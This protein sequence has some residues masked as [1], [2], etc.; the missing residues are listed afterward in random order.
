MKKRNFGAPTDTSPSIAIARPDDTR[1]KH[2]LHQ[3]QERR[4]RRPGSR[5]AAPALV[6]GSDEF[7]KAQGTGRKKAVK[8]ASTGGKKPIRPGM[9]SAGSPWDTDE[10]RAV[11]KNAVYIEACKS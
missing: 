7:L 6:K 5:K 8:V 2:A 9:S 4:R 10:M 1:S 3:G 11:P